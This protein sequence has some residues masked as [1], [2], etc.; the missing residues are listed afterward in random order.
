MKGFKL[1][2]LGLLTALVPAGLHYLMGLDWTQF[3]SPV[4]A[5]IVVGGLTVALRFVTDSP[6]FKK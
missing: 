6:V 1:V 5:P 3:V 4:V 2:T